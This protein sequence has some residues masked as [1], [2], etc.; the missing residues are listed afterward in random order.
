M[1]KE[2]KTTDL[3][4]V[5][6]HQ[7]VGGTTRKF[8]ELSDHARSSQEEYATKG[9]NVAGEIDGEIHSKVV[10]ICWFEKPIRK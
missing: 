6:A 7:D 4:A 2:K 1:S 9:D 8:K 5:Q 3:R 10:E